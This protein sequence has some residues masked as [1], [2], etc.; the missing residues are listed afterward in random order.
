M[1]ICCGSFLRILINIG[2]K[3]TS[4]LLSGNQISVIVNDESGDDFDR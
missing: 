2:M 4:K 1:K 3:I